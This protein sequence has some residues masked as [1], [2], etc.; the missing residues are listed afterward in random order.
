[1]E[2]VWVAVLAESFEDALRLLCQMARPLRLCDDFRVERRGGRA[3]IAGS[4]AVGAAVEYGE[5]Y[6]AVLLSGGRLYVVT[7]APSERKV[8][9]GEACASV[10]RVARGECPRLKYEVWC[11]RCVSADGRRYR[12]C[13]AET[14]TKSEEVRRALFRLGLGDIGEDKLDEVVRVLSSICQ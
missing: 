14:E 5:G 9:S 7:Y 2:V 4:R 11:R 1:V 3:F 6:R 8:V 10:E 13:W 12:R